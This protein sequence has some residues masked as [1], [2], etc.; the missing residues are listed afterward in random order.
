VLSRG[1]VV[2]A[3]VPAELVRQIG[4]QVLEITARQPGELGARI[5][6][7]FRLRPS[8][9]D[10]TVRIEHEGAHRLVPELVEAFGADIERIA[11]SHPSLEDVYVKVTGHRFFG[12]QEQRR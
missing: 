3:G 12:E 9:V 8:I 5:A 10:Q 11:V 2:A 6:A 4:G 1:R 7:R